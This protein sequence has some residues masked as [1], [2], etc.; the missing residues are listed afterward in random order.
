MPNSLMIDNWTLQD[1][2]ALLSKG[3]DPRLVGELSLSADRAGH[4]FSPVRAGVVQ[5]DALLTLLT[6]IVCF[7]SLIVDKDYVHTWQRDGG[8]LAPLDHASLVQAA[9]YSLPGLPELRDSMV[10]ELCVTPTLKDSLQKI[11]QAWEKT[12]TTPDPHLSALVW[13]GAGMLARSHMTSTPYFG[14]PVRRRLVRE[15]RMF[16]SQQSAV[17][18]LNAFVETE[19]TKMFRYRGSRM[20]GTCG[21]LVL[22]PVPVQVIEEATTID[23]L[24]PIACNVRDKHVGLRSWLAEYQAALEEEDERKQL[25]FE[26]TLSKL[27]K[28]MEV[29]YGAD[30]AGSLG[31]SLSAAI[32]KVDVPRQL[33]DGVLNSFGIRATL[34]D[35]VLAPRGQKALSKLLAMLG[36]GQSA[37]GREIQIGCNSRYASPTP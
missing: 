29:K 27:G 12:G 7:D 22:P 19:R 9:D 2:E 35:L 8:H 32:F 6:N 16:V 30:K 23:D 1:V 26:K 3:L 15:T 31:I 18:K 24:I 5:I 28:S 20:S 11:Q 37:L 25:K 4:A 13:G 10:N 34:S 14:H 17:E 21:Q 36:E 33:V